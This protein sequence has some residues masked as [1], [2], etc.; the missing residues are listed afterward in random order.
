MSKVFCIGLNKTA[1]SSIVTAWA[2]L[3]LAQQIYWPERD[4][5]SYAMVLSAFSKNYKLLFDRVDKFT[6]FKDRPFNTDSMYKLLDKYYLDSKFILTVRDEDK[7]WDTVD[8]WLSNLVPGHHV[9][10][11]MRLEKIEVYK[12]HFEATDLSKE[13]FINYYRKYNQ[14]VRDYFKGNPNFIEMNL[15]QGDGWDALCPFLGLPIL[16]KPFPKSNVNNIGKSI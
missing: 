14:E 7:W 13:Q 5:Q 2:E 16:D 11:R 6:Y 1:T 15:E 10:E 12:R 8:R 3:G 9:N 4:P